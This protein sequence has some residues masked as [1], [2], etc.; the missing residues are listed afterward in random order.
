[1]LHP[2]TPGKRNKILVIFLKFVPSASLMEGKGIINPK[3]EFYCSRNSRLITVYLQLISVSALHI[4]SSKK[5]KVC[6]NSEYHNES[7]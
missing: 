1:M 4:Q 6:A 3:L 7:T 2:V 5:M